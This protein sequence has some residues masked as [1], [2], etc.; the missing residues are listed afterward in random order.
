MAA[1]AEEDASTDGAE[2]MP[3]QLTDLP[4]VHRENIADTDGL[5]SPTSARCARLAGGRPLSAPHLVFERHWAIIVGNS[6]MLLLR[7]D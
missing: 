6:V 7:S 1:A 2:T 4:C 3:R 5:L